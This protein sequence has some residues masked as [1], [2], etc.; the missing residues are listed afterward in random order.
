MQNH[1]GVGSRA[2][3]QHESRIVEVERL[4][5]RKQE[6]W[7]CDSYLQKYMIQVPVYPSSVRY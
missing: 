7:L 5:V 6:V 1:L 3:Q 2:A 4:C